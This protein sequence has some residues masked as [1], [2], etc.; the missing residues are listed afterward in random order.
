MPRKATAST[1]PSASDE[2][3]KALNS[4]MPTPARTP[5]AND[6]PLVWPGRERAL[7]LMDAIFLAAATGRTVLNTT[8]DQAVATRVSHR[9]ANP[10]LLMMQRL[11][12]RLE[13]ALDEL[14]A[15]DGIITYLMVQMND[16]FEG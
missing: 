15:A 5:D 14:L 13:D 11:E 7:E 16:R 3:L 12:E 9:N 10:A 1:P 8:F 4:A 6:P 2:M